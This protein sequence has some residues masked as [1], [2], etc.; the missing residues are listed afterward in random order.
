M[1]EHGEVSEMIVAWVPPHCAML[2]A[3]SAS[4]V[5]QM[6]C[7]LNRSRHCQAVHEMDP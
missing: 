6:G 2:A 4:R 5:A 7:F 3:T 1:G